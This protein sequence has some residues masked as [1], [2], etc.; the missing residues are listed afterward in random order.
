MK[1]LWHR[2]AGSSVH[3][4]EVIEDGE[5]VTVE[6]ATHHPRHGDG[7]V[8]LRRWQLPYVIAEMTTAS[9][10]GGDGFDCGCRADVRHVHIGDAK[11]DDVLQ[12]ESVDARGR[13]AA[14]LVAPEHERELF[15][16]LESI[17]L[18]YLHDDVWGGEDALDQ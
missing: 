3:V 13:R 1:T 17:A 16:Q 5:L 10:P 6:I 11:G 9:Y 14:C 2:G 8:E 18:A 15:K 12:I 7:A 4:H